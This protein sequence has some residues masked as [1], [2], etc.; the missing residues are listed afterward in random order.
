MRTIETPAGNFVESDLIEGLSGSI[1]T[2]RSGRSYHIKPGEDFECDPRD[3][4]ELIALGM[5][6][7]TLN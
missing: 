4:G 7:I 2:C 6:E 1:I 3:R 5:I